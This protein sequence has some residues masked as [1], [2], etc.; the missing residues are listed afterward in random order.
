MSR[1]TEAAEP[2]SVSA[3]QM[4]LL[5]EE[6][7][8]TLREMEEAIV[9]TR[10]Q[11]KTMEMMMRRVRRMIESGKGAGDVARANNAAAARAATSEIIREVQAARH[12]AQQAQFKL[13]AAEGSTMAEI[14]RG[15]G[16]SRQLVSRMVKEPTARRKKS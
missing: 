5:R 2:K 1:R 13:A 3:S 6:S 11:L 4:N 7:I 8:R 16:V 14:A 9:R 12:R 10:D 15:W